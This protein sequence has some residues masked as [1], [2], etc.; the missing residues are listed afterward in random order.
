MAK[1]IKTPVF[2]FDKD[3]LIENYCSFKQ[4]CE[5]YLDKFKICY[6]VKTNSL[7]EVLKTLNGEKCGFEIASLD[8]LNLVRSLKPKSFFGIFNGSC[9][10][11]AELK[12]ALKNDFLINIDNF[13]EI[14]K[15]S[16]IKRNEEIGIRVAFE[17]GKLGIDESKILEAFKKATQ[18]SLK[19]VALS[20]HAGTQATLLHFRKMISKLSAVMENLL[21]KGFALKYLDIGGGFPDKIQLKSLSLTLD[22]YFWE[23]SKLKKFN[24]IIIL[25]PGRVLVSD[26]MSLLTKV[27]YT[28]ENFG[29]KYA[30]CD[31]GINLL[32]KITMSRYFIKKL[33]KEIEGK[34]EHY[35][36][37]GPLLFKNDIFGEYIGQLKEGDILKIEN[38]GAYCYNLAWEISYKKPKVESLL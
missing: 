7:P 8:E 10:T 20:C 14:E 28:K 18:F 22:D 5:K 31:A 37:A 3:K 32:P 9:K 15:I 27:H 24:C 26:S 29:K 30:I 2:V 23:I 35:L 21:R 36:L 13:T 19:P 38:V 11:E 6:S 1:E 12:L 4:L 25:E 17:E 33:S 16:A 34:K